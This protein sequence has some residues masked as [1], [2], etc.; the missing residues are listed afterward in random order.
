MT[1]ADVLVIGAGIAGLKAAHDLQKRG[2][3][4]VVLEARDRIGGRVHS[5]EADGITLD[6]GASWIHGINNNPL[7]D[8][9]RSLNMKTHEFTV[10]SFQAGGR[11]ILYFDPD[12][13][14]LS[15]SATN[16][17]IA[18]VAR[19]DEELEATIAT[20]SEGSSYADAV[21]ATLKRLDW[22]VRR[23]Q[24][25]REFMQHRTEEQ[26]GAWI[27]DLDAHGLDDDQVDGEEVVFPNGFAELA[28]HLAEELNILLDHEVTHIEWQSGEV[29]V[30]T[31]NRVFV[32]PRT[33]ITVPVGILKSGSFKFTPELPGTHQAALSGL[34]MNAFEKIF[35]TFDEEFWPS[36]FYAFRQQGPHGD[37]W[38]SFYNLTSMQGVPT[39]L[40]FAAGP[41][42]R[43]IRNLNQQQVQASIMSELRRL[44]GS[45]VPDPARITVT[46]WQGDKFARGAYAYMKVGSKTADHETLATPVADTLYFAGEATWEEDPA[47]VTAAFMSGARAAARLP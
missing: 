28:E 23:S 17:F 4:V 26:Y 11:P 36:N 39:L 45:T 44:F 37:W 25:I 14:R 21:A 32:A 19:F 35:L 42:A 38:H 22:G 3:R 6:L 5:V 31:Q 46:D 7:A 34:E 33:V 24:R 47:T 15:D 43:A 9:V 18:D 27:E 8:T 41:A 30:H 20:T 2:L 16:A 1:D 40:T 29:R 10:G 12:G 13:E